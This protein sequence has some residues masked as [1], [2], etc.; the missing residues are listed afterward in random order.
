MPKKVLSRFYYDP[1]ATYVADDFNAVHFNEIVK[2]CKQLGISINNQKKNVLID[3]ILLKHCESLENTVACQEEKITDDFQSAIVN[4]E[5][6][7]AVVQQSDGESGLKCIT[8]GQF[9]TVSVKVYGTYDDPLFKATEIGELLG[10]KDLR[11]TLRHFDDGTVQTMHCTD[12][13]GRNRKFI[14]LTEQGLYK[15]LF[16]SRVPVAKQFQKWVFGVIKEIRLKGIYEMRSRMDRIESEYLLERNQKNKLIEELEVEK[17]KN[18]IN[19]IAM[20]RMKNHEKRK[21]GH[22]YVLT[23]RTYALQYVYKI[24][25]AT[26]CR[27]RICSLNTANMSPDQQLYLCWFLK[28]DEPELVEKQIHVWL[29]EHRYN[30]RREFFVISFDALTSFIEEVCGKHNSNA[31][32]L[33]AMNDQMRAIDTDM[34]G[35]VPAPIAFP[36]TEDEEQ[37]EDI[38]VGIKGAKRIKTIASYFQ[39]LN[40]PTSNELTSLDSVLK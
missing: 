3:R 36:V 39:K 14:M 23:S 17:S 29:N 34:P 33:A 31:V 11:S 2:V 16:I 26:D 1:K 24:G 8:D 6:T 19:T 12:S 32:S 20:N 25:I 35:Q 38:D 18:R 13:I 22:V 5:K 27:K 15:L 40:E 30:N 10:I 37:V 4:K 28:V 21:S 7:G 9:G